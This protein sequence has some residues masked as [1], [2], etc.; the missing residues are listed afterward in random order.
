MQ[1]LQKDEIMNRPT[2]ARCPGGFAFFDGIDLSGQIVKNGE[3]TP[4]LARN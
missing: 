4:I 3:L 1:Y 2:T